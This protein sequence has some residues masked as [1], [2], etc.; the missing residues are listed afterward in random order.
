MLLAAEGLTDKE[1][2][3]RLGITRGTVSTHW[4]RLREKVG[5][6]SRTEAIMKTLGQRLRDTAR[7]ADQALA[8]HKVLI[9]QAEDYVIFSLDENG[10]ILDWN[11]GVVRVLGYAEEEFVGQNL[12]LIFTPE[13]ARDGEHTFEMQRALEH[14]RFLDMRWHVRKDGTQI[15]VRGFLI[16]MRDPIT[17]AFRK[18]SKIMRD[19]TERKGLEEEVKRLQAR[20][21]K[22]GFK[23]GG[24][25]IL[26][27]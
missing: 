20:I 1:I 2:A 5:A 3:D 17:G 12:S 11:N 16:A 13:D 26:P 22:G 8:D 4:V 14:G 27:G 9:E 19:D 24:Q 10:T 7:L 25:S 6:R 23:A 21:S 15:W 18:F